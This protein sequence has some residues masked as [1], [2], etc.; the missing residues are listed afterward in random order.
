[1]QNHRLLIHQ[2]QSQK[3][4][5]L[6]TLFKDHESRIRTQEEGQASPVSVEEYH[7]QMVT[8]EMDGYLSQH[9]L[10]LEEHPLVWWK[11]QQSNFPVLVKLAQ[12]YL[13]ICASSSA[14]NVVSPFRAI[15]KPDRVDMLVF[16]SKN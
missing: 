10:D 15:M 12:K 2:P 14:R 8:K 11:S 7:R 5:N 1:M 13:C 16:L 3:K 4:R 6:G 9:R